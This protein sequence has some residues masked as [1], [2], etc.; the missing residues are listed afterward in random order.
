[1]SLK[2]LGFTKWRGRAWKK[3][4]QYRLFYEL[5]QRYVT[6]I[7][8]RVFFQFLEAVTAFDTLMHL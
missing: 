4:P 5:L 7:L 1:M 3:A 2:A 6:Q 8:E